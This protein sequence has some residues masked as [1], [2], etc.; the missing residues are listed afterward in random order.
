MIIM[1][2]T[3]FGFILLGA[4]FLLIR[5]W[6]DKKLGFAYVLSFFLAF[7]LSTALLTQAFGVFTYPVV[8]AVHTIVLIA[9]TVRINFWE[10]FVHW[11]DAALFWRK[12]RGVDWALVLVLVIAFI[13]L[14]PVHYN[15]S[16]KYTVITTEEYRE[17]EN[18]R[19]PYPYFSDEWYAIALIKDLISSRS[20]LFRDP[21]KREYTPFTNLEFAF[22]SLLAEL[23][24][25]LNL[26]PLTDYVNMIIVSGLLIC[27]LVYLF[28]RFDNVGKLSSALAASAVL[29]ITN[30]ANLPGTWDLIPLIL[31][32]ISMLLSFFFFSSSDRRMIFMLALLTLLFY[33]PLAP[34]YALA[35]IFYFGRMEALP[36]AQKVKAISGILI[37]AVLTGVI[38]AL[39]CWLAWGAFGNSVHDFLLSKIFPRPFPPDAMPQ[40]AIWNIVPIPVLAL[41][42]LGVF[43]VARRRSWLAGMAVLGLIYWVVYSRFLFHFFLDYERV[44]VVTSIL[45]TLV[46][47]Y[48]L[49]YLVRILKESDVFRRNNSLNYF[50]IGVL[51]FLLFSSATYTRRDNWQE[52]TLSHWGLKRVFRPAAPANVYLHPDDLRIFQEIKGAKFLSAPW[53]GTV[54]G[55]ATGNYPLAMKEGTLGGETTDF[56]RFMDRNCARKYRMVTWDGIQY[57]YLPPFDC[58]HFEFV[59]KSAE[60]FYLYRVVE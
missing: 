59:D 3:V 9:V 46:A 34:F 47:G 40:F 35:V 13:H 29:Y 12:A 50:Q 33:P 51:V 49:D 30:G 6:K 38:L 19:Y 32:I 14:Y 43:S 2:Q 21:T 25:L 22:H 7:H 20:L 1:P 4:P 31:G 60:G 44:V 5:E 16:G 55:V 48:G 53:K 17:I 36:W 18:M 57:V 58:P 42:V 27:A 41:S 15:Y 10:F 23:A 8:I 39:S 54:I 26:D 56:K 45:L 28:L 52:L 24:L 11:R 37:A